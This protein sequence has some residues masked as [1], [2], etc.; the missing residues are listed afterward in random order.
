MDEARH[1]AFGRLALR[2][3]YADMGVI[4]SQDLDELSDS[5]DDVA[6]ET[7]RMLAERD[8]TGSIGQD[9]GSRAHALADTASQA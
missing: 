1:I 2:D 7:E 6:E 3:A 8:R 5:D 9:D 4:D